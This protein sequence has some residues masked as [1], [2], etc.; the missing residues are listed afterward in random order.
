MEEKNA[1]IP[2]LTTQS[3]WLLFAKIVGFAFTLLLPLL[4]VRYLSQEEVGIYRQVFLVIVNA[5]AI[6]PLGFGIS[7]YYFLSRETEERRGA[8]VF[9]TLLFN[10]A[11]G[12]V[13]CLTLFLYPQLL[14]NITQS[15]EMTRLAPKIGVVIWLWVFSTFLE[16][17]AVANREPK[18]ATAFIIL[19]Q[20][21]KTALLMLAVV[22]FATVE[23]FIYAAMAQALIQSIILLVYL[24]SRFPKF[25][26]KF[27]A[28][29]FREQLFYAL[30]Y[31]LAGLLWTLQTDIHNYFVFYHFNAAGFAVYSTGCFELPLIAMLAES[32]GAVM[33]PRMSE[34]EASADKSEMK[35]LSA[36]V[37]QK[38]AF[39]YFPI[40]I[41]LMITATT[42]ITTLFTKN[43]GASVPIFLVNLTLLPV[44]IWVTD[45]IVRAYKE[46]GRLLLT[47]RAFILVGLIAALYFGI[48]HFDLRGMIAIV[49]AVALVDKFVSTWLV[50]R[51]LA[52]KRQDIGLLKNVGKTALA[53]L[54]AG[55]ATLLCY[56]QFE[57]SVAAWGA[58]LAQAI[59]PTVKHSLTDFAAGILVLTFAAAIF[60]PI[61]LLMMN[62]FG[63]IEDAEKEKLKSFANRFSSVFRKFA[64][65]NPKSETL[66]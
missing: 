1:K 10:F 21:T 34:L 31:G 27:D 56:R 64:V 53:S 36:R 17:I 44:Y 30:P 4:I 28:Q 60:A 50:L 47:A 57:E 61:Y 54:I 33:I 29:F 20:F 6:L 65:Q 12:A 59:L 52:V 11:V 8:A 35:R 2:S 14:G 32:V 45:P 26:Q 22:M 7:V 42:F 51:K 40:Y 62:R 23:S 41:F 63:V 3:A 46:L 15:D 19:A 39:F 38:L 55:A 24:G 43:Y 18:M 16:T 9:N 66:N 37:M 48:R 58:S 13:A 49:I 5:N 25:W